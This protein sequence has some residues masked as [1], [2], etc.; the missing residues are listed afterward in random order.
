VRYRFGHSM[1]TET[2]N[3]DTD[4]NADG[5]QQ[6]S[7]IEA[8]ANPLGYLAQRAGSIVAGSVSQVAN[9]IDEFVTGALRNNR[10]HVKT[11][12]LRMG[13]EALYR[14]PRTTKPEA[15]HKVFP[16]LLRGI[17]ITRPNQVWAMDITYIPMAKGL[18]Y[19]AVVLEWFSRRVLAWRA[20]ITM[21]AAFCIEALQEAPAR[22][23]K[24]EIFN[25]DQGSQSPARPSR[26]CWQ[27]SRSGSAWTARARGATACSSS[28]CG[29]RS[30]ARRSTCTPTRAS[31]GANCFESPRESSSRESIIRSRYEKI[32]KDNRVVMRLVACRIDECHDTFSSQLAQSVKLIA[33]IL[34]LRPIPPLELLP[35]CGIV[36]EPFSQ[37]GAWGD[38][39]HPVVDGGFRLAD[40]A[41]PKSVDQHARAIIGRRRLVSPLDPHSILGDFAAHHCTSG[42]VAA[43]IRAPSICASPA[44]IETYCLSPRSS[45]SSRSVSAMRSRT[46]SNGRSAPGMRRPPETMWKP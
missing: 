24:P 14:R 31:E 33:M 28:A 29:G 32:A 9:G 2:L 40:A 4:Q 22:H 3:I 35:A 20:S 21:D 30:S 15:G 34:K 43:S 41:W 25:T 7:L 23:G 19:L 37:L 6:M 5:V 44:R 12:M 11:L 46:S 36:P 16:Y 1:L 10:R 8:F 45:T 13:M 39:L 42:E 17:E 18:V 27:P 26:A 38:L